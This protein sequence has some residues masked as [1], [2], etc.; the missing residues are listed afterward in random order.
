MAEELCFRSAIEIA[1]LV[2]DK[3]MSPVEVVETFLARIEKINPRLNAYVTVTEDLARRAA[4][5]AE[6]AVMEGAELG[7]LHGVPFAVKDLVFTAGVRTTAGSLVYRDFVPEADSGVVARLKQAG[8]V[9][10]GKTNTPEFGYKAT[11]ENL[12]FGET[13]NPWDLEKTPGGSSGGAGAATATGLSPLAVGTD[14]GGSIRIPSSF[15]G[16]FG[17]KPTF[18]RVPNLPGFGG[19]RTLAHT[20]PMTRTVADAALM[21][22][23]IG[24]PDERDR[25]ALPAENTTF[26]QALLN[27]PRELRIGWSHDLGYAAVDRQV[28][29]VVEKAVQAFAENGW[30]VEE[31][32]PGF[33][34]P[35]EIFNTTVRAENFV[36]AGALLEKHA[37][38]L[39]PGMRAFTKLGTEITTLAYLQATQARDQLCHQLAAFFATHDL[40]VTPTVAVPPF[41]INTRPKEID[42]RKTHVLGWLPFTYPFNLTGNPAASVPCG[43]TEDGL[44]IGMQIVGRRFADALV[45]QAS[46]VFEQIHPWVHRCPML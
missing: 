11:T 26:S 21:L 20:G 37:D 12:L 39:D 2:R 31:A 35:I 32:H 38:L 24:V 34:D 23:V 14:G 46:A 36:F 10:L 9:M 6:R 8:A 3:T 40:L 42:G 43:W 18:G 16:I 33:T 5:E 45:L 7:L 1:R 29:T 44:P 25:L 19:W 13:R 22:D 41:P 4:Q 17:I 15:C 30:G 28:R 27:P